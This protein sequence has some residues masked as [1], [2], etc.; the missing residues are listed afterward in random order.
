MAKPKKWNEMSPAEQAA[1]NEARAAAK[2]ER[3]AAEKAALEAEVKGP[4][5]KGPL[6]DKKKAQTKK[7]P[8]APKTASAGTPAAPQAA[9]SEIKAFD[10]R[11]NPKWSPDGALSNA[12]TKVLPKTDIP[13]PADTRAFDFEK[14]GTPSHPAVRSNIVTPD[15]PTEVPT[16]AYEQPKLQKGK[17]AKAAKAAKTIAQDVAEVKPSIPMKPLPG[18]G[19]MEGKPVEQIIDK[20]GAHIERKPGGTPPPGIPERRAVPALEAQKVM[21]PTGAIE[22]VPGAKPSTNSV[23]DAMRAS[24]KAGRGAASWKVDDEV[25]AAYESSLK[26]GRR[27]VPSASAKIARTAGSAAAKGVKW[28]AS[29]SGQ[30]AIGIAKEATEPIWKPITEFAKGH[31]ERKA[32]HAAAD[33]AAK[34]ATT[35]KGRVAARAM[36]AAATARSAGAVGMMGARFGMGAAKIGLEGLAVYGLGKIGEQGALAQTGSQAAMNRHVRSG[37]KQGLEVTHADPSIW[38][39]AL[40]GSPKIKVHDPSQDVKADGKS[41]SQ[42]RRERGQAKFEENEYNRVKKAASRNTITG[43]YKGKGGSENV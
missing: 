21:A 36:G 5:N 29:K 11:V 39:M 31:A 22:P 7:A 23:A 28:A 9:K 25:K 10:R 14:A 24:M 38:R 43:S 34:S 13:A 20:R 33:A 12:D 8:K 4:G 37:K 16:K 6:A 19:S 3:K 35:L 32:A 18:Q 40:G 2:A 42:K 15:A 26:M 30:L 41:L 27:A 17:L 1:E